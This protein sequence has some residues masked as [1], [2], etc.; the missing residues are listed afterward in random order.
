[1][2]KPGN[3][4]PRNGE[5]DAALGARIRELRRARGDT[6]ASLGERVGLTYQQVQK[7]ENGANR[8]SALMLIKLAQALNTTVDE[9]LSSVEPATPDVSE[10]ERLLDAFARIQSAKKR[11]LVLQ[12][13]EAF[14]DSLP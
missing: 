10:V 13:V 4:K 2:T 1:M 12:L 7:Y 6:Q 14:A 5:L 9:L 8:I 3:A 11:T